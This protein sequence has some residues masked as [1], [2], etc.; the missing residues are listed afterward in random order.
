[1]PRPVANTEHR[2][3]RQVYENK[4]GELPNKEP[5]SRFCLGIKLDQA[6]ENEPRVESL[7]DVSSKEDGEEDYLSAEVDDRG[8][9]KVRKG[10]AQVFKLPQNG[11]ELNLRHRIFG[12]TWMFCHTND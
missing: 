11:E 4:F 7:K 9:V 5:P 2:A 12:N 6:E 8:Q 1:M 3:M 10:A